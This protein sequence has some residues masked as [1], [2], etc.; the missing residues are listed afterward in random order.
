MAAIQDPCHRLMIIW[1]CR[2][3]GGTRPSLVKVVDLQPA[4]MVI[5]PMTS[6]VRGSQ[7]RSWRALTP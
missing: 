1:P 2:V 7:R 4:V 3:S 6:A 5:R